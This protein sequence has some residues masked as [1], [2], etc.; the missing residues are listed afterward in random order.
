MKSKLLAAFLSVSVCAPAL[1]EQTMSDL[2]TAADR[3]NAQLQLANSLSGA[4]HSYGHST[5]IVESG[6]TDPALISQQM[7]DSYNNAID[8]VLTT[9]YL[10]ASDIFAAEHNNAINNLHMAIND[11]VSATAVLATVATVADMAASAD[12]TQEQLQVQAALSTTDMSISTADVENYNNALG[13]VESYAQQA[14]AFLS[15]S[16]NANI[17]GAVDNYAAAN[18]VAVASYTAVSYAQNI[19]QL[20]I[21]FG[22]SAYLEF[23]GAFTA[24]TKSVEDI[25]GQVGYT[26]N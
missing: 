25:W 10:T 3:I 13:A 11:L 19:D 8:T 15:A 12:T 20:I 6:V 2:A 16:G 4:I 23:N 18:N 1:A 14:A 26:V 21:Q 24:N 17:T 9:S 5:T 22:N 7:V